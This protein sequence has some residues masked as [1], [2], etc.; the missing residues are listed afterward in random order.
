MGDIGTIQDHRLNL[1]SGASGDC[2]NGSGNGCEI[3]FMNSWAL[4]WSYD[5]WWIW[6]WICRDELGWLH[7]EE[8]FVVAWHRHFEACSLLKYP[9]CAD[10]NWFSTYYH[11]QIKSVQIV[12]HC[13][14][15]VNKQQVVEWGVRDDWFP[16]WNT[17][18]DVLFTILHYFYCNRAL[19]AL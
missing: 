5:M 6:G 17:R 8:R 3:W 12:M 7:H 19:L 4:G 11:Y 18:I 9:S 16:G 10:S 15:L 14:G 1:F 13:S 2:K